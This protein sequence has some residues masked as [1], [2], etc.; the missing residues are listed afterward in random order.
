[1]NRIFRWIWK[2]KDESNLDQ[3]NMEDKILQQMSWPLN[4]TYD[5]L[6]KSFFNNIPNEIILYI[7]RYLSVHDL[8]NISLVCRSFKLTA[9]HD[10][11]W[12]TKC[13]SK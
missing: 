6:S 5:A 11:I 13:K 7:F 3:L 8:C 2:S 9:D 12:K 1:M 10:E 4:E